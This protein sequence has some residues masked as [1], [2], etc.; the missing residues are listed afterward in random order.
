MLFTVLYVLI[1]AYFPVIIDS[2][3]YSVNIEGLRF[4]TQILR[5]EV[6]DNTLDECLFALT[7]RY[8]YKIDPQ[9]LAVLDRIPL[10][11]RYNHLIADRTNIYLLTANEIII[12]DKT[13]LAF[14]S[15]IGVEYGDYVPLMTTSSS[16]MSRPSSAIMLMSSSGNKSILKMFD[17]DD[18][19][20][21]RK[22]TV[23]KII[24][25]IVDHEH[26]SLVTLDVQNNLSVYS[27]QLDKKCTSHLSFRGIEI[28]RKGNNYVV[29]SDHGVFLISQQSDIIDFQ[30][31]LFSA[32]CVYNQLIYTTQHG[33]VY[34]DPLT[35]RTRGLCQDLTAVHELVPLE[36]SNEDYVFALDRLHGVSLLNCG[37]MT[38]RILTKEQPF[39]PIP[40]TA[41]NNIP[42]DS[43]WYI[44]LGA[45]SQYEYAY[46][47][48][49]Q[50]RQQSFPVFI[51]TTALYRVKL[52]GF[53][54]KNPAQDIIEH[55]GINGWLVLEDYRISEEKS[56]FSIGPDR[57]L[58]NNGIIIK[59]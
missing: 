54:D 13:N 30:P 9:T 36:Y 46:Q 56:E 47:M 52:G 35:L 16:S 33:V 32:K 2:S 31:T 5:E 43:L 42:E 17:I 11:Q 8:L 26:H 21:V 18:G 45:F 49:I 44:Q 51:D 57:Y 37:T 29:R 6:I 25:Y 20:L 27:S 38:I 34:I 50:F 48:Y 15:G 41:K 1:Q 14:K 24:S 4:R 22:L 53:K 59:E 19:K 23:D 12:I 3:I 58:Y 55:T 40:I 28:G 7:T 10:P 39:R